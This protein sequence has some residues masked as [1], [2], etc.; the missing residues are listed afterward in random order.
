MKRTS[1][2]PGCWATMATRSASRIWGVSACC[3][4]KPG[5]YIPKTSIKAWRWT[6]CSIHTSIWW[7]W[8]ARPAAARPC[9]PW[10]R[11]WSWWSRRGSTTRWSSPVTPRKSP[12]ASASCPALKKRRWCPGWQP[13]RI[14]WRCCTSRTRTWTGR[15]ATSWRRPTSSSNRSTS[16]AGV[17]SRTPSYCWMSARTWRPPRSR[18]SSPAAARGPRSSAPATW[19]RS[20]PTTWARWPRVWLT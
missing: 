3:R 12:R 10:R 14:P 15:W 16:C 6:P 1:S 9:W 8:P 2:R 19:R 4:A 13:S 7:S 20:I 11:P 17:A 18:P 5:A